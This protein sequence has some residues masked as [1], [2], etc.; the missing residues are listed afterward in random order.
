MN[1]FQIIRNIE[2]VDTHGVPYD[3]VEVYNTSYEHSTILQIKPADA[4]HLQNIFDYADKWGYS[5]V[6]LISTKEYVKP[7]LKVVN[8]NNFT[9]M[10]KTMYRINKRLVNSSKANL[11]KVSVCS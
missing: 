4:F 5:E 10:D 2:D 8:C 11:Q 6:W 7:T 1:L 3:V 9:W